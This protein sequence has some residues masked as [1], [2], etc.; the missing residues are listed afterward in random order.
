MDAQRRERCESA[1]ATLAQALAERGR[2]PAYHVF[3][4]SEEIGDPCA[5]ALEYFDRESA[6]VVPVLRAMRVAKLEAVSAYDPALHDEALRHI[7]PQCA[8][9]PAVVVV[10]PAERL[11][12]STLTSFSRLLRSDRPVQIIVPVAGEPDIDVGAIALGHEGVFVL[13]SSS[14]R[15][16]HMA[17]GLAEMGRTLRPAVAVVYEEAAALYRYDPDGEGVYA[18]RFE[19]EKNSPAS[20]ML[21]A[22]AAKPVVALPEEESAQQAYQK[23]LALLANPEGLT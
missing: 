7:E 2:T 3:Q 15:P 6:N 10:E 19:L 13:Q 11:A 5:A 12:Q 9:L 16:E 4:A 17:K 14:A 20:E 18:D 8:G 22:L 21:T 1:H 23:V